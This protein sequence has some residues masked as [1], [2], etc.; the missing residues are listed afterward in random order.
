M[1]SSTAENGK[2]L[3]ERGVVQIVRAKWPESM[4]VAVYTQ[5]VTLDA[6]TGTMIVVHSRGN[7]LVPLLE[8]TDSGEVSA[9]LADLLKQEKMEPRLHQKTPLFFTEPP[10]KWTTT[11]TNLLFRR[12]DGVEWSAFADDDTSPITV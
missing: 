7:W 3:D 11:G 6:Y 4:S 5:Y 1:K 8:A 10:D 9:A 12:H 2:A